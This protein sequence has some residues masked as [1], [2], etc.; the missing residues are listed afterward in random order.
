MIVYQLMCKGICALFRNS[1]FEVRSSTVFLSEESANKRISAML[2]VCC[3]ET[4]IDY[5]DRGTAKV[6][7]LPLEVI[8]D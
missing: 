2:D 6:T 7:V 4:K 5:C 1:K 8:E 3:D